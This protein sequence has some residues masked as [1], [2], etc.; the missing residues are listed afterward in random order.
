M[1]YIRPNWWKY[2]QS[3]IGQAVEE[4]GC[5]EAAT[6]GTE[7]P[8]NKRGEPYPENQEEPEGVLGLHRV[9]DDE[10]RQMPASVKGNH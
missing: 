9:R 3:G 7:N 2:I 6:S 1:I 5:N 4:N 10:K 8:V